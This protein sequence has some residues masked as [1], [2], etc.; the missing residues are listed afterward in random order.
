MARVCWNTLLVL[1]AVLF[2]SGAIAML[3]MAVLNQAEY[4]ET[5]IH[6]GKNL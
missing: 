1:A 3:I 5:E 6:I 2:F 4:E